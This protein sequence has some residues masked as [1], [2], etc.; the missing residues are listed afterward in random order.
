M[1]YMSMLNILML[2]LLVSCTAISNKGDFKIVAPDDISVKAIQELVKEEVDAGKKVIL[3]FSATYCPPCKKINKALQDTTQFLP[4][5]DIVVVEVKGEVT[6]G[7]TTHPLWSKLN[8]RAVPTIFQVDSELNVLNKCM[9]RK[10]NTPDNS[11]QK[12]IEIFWPDKT[13][14]ELAYEKA[15]KAG[16]KT[17]N[18]IMSGIRYDTEL[19]EIA[20][21][22]WF[23]DF[24]V[25]KA[26]EYS[27]DKVIV[28]GAKALNE[29]VQKGD[30]LKITAMVLK[31]VG[32]EQ[33]LESKALF[34]ALEKFEKLIF[35]DLKGF[36]FFPEEIYELTALKMLKTPGSSITHELSDKFAQLQNLEILDQSFSKIRFPNNINQLVNLRHI[37]YYNNT[38]SQPKSLFQ[39]PNLQTLAYNVKDENQLAGINQ[40]DK[41]EFLS[42]NRFHPDISKL[43]NLKSL[44]LANPLTKENAN[45]NENA[46][47][48][49]ELLVLACGTEP[50]LPE[51]IG[52]IKTLRGLIFSNCGE[53][54]AVPENYTNLKKLKYLQFGFYNTIP[55]YTIPESLTESPIIYSRRLTK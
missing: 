17:Q 21:K 44:K 33:Q 19:S 47:P 3:Y 46:F 48:T 23:E 18:A 9:S 39:L 4:F 32:A 34:K 7:G 26:N 15:Y 42:V 55:E 30:H 51:S 24:F 22:S 38:V 10:W 43:K 40:L 8:V 45:F 11:L 31:A 5:G 27:K 53:L 35:L 41:L 25:G 37:V 2:N 36:R 54:R 29:L 49:L 6:I 1:K 50:R 16:S 28:N 13:D 20:K 12:F 52:K 14:D